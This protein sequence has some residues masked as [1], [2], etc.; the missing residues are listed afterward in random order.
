MK[1]AKS[2]ATA[3][4]LARSLKASDLKQV[5]DQLQEALVSIEKREAKKAATKQA[6]DLKKPKDLMAKMSLSASD[7]RGLMPAQPKNKEQRQT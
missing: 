3:N 4:R 7:L 1:I 2:K 5:I 6:A